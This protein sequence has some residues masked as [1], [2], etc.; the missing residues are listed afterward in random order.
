[1]CNASVYFLLK[2]DHQE[3][4]YFTSLQSDWVESLKENKYGWL[5][6]IDSIVYYEE[7]QFYTK[8]DAVLKI[9]QYLGMPWNIIYIFRIVPRNI[10]DGIYDFI[11]SHR[12]RWFGKKAR[13]PMP[14][15]KW[16]KR[17]ID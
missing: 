16:N 1:M 12:Y 6:H 8:S 5:N 15:P 9:M 3:R 11:A 13:C 4:L 14:K 10:R 7:G 17:F 2:R